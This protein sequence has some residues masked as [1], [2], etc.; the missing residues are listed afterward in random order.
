MQSASKKRVC[1]YYDSKY[2]LLNTIAGK[3]KQISTH[4]KKKCMQKQGLFTFM[5]SLSGIKAM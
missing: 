5:K 3:F 1:Y 2:L 4:T